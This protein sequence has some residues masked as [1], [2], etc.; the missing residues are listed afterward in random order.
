M[1]LT[2]AR[3]IL[4]QHLIWLRSCVD[5]PEPPRPASDDLYEAI[6][7][8]ISVLP[9]DSARPTAKERLNAIRRIILDVEGF[10]PFETRSRDPRLVCWRQCV[11]L[12]M[13]NE[14]YRSVEM[15]KASAYDHATMWWGV[16]RLRGYLSCGDRAAIA[17]WEELNRIING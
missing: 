13:A 15:A 10:D 9:R 4:E 2:E 12:L 8:A 3:K 1:T 7:V 14:G 17:T 11:W 5:D 16:R 6:E